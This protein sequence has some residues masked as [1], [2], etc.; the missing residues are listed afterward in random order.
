MITIAYDLKQGDV[1]LK[2]T[3]LAAVAKWFDDQ[4]MQFVK[5]AT[6]VHRKSVFE[7][8]VYLIRTTPV[9][10]GRLRGSWAPFLDKYGQ[11]QRALRWSETQSP[12]AGAVQ[13][14]RLGFDPQEFQKGKSEGDYIDEAFSTTLTTNV[15]YAEE[16][17]ARVGF[18]GAA[19]AWGDRRY[20]RNFERF[21]G[22]AQKQGM[23]PL[24][25]DP[26][27]DPSVESD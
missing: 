18:I 22:A 4:H 26:S 3:T 20:N 13:G 11:I 7:I 21:Y 6:L 2:D 1:Q 19:Q 25:D 16:A 12:M 27:V 17:N 5:S 14:E 8:L 24:D 23:I 15:N 9:D 10:T